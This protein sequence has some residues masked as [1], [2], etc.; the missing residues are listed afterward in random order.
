VVAAFAIATVPAAAR[1]FPERQ[2][3]SPGDVE[4]VLRQAVAEAQA[5]DRL[6]DVAVVDRVGNVLAFYAMDRRGMSLFRV[7]AER[8]VESPAGLADPNFPPVLQTPLAAIAK[9]ITGAYLSS[10]GNAFSTRTAN[11]I[12]Q[13]NFLPG[14]ENL[15]GG[16]LF[17]VQFSSLP[18]SDLNVRFASDARGFIDP[19]AGPKRSPLGLAADPGG[20]PLYKEG[21]LVGGVGVIADGRYGLDRDV[22]DRDEDD[23]ELIAVAAARGFDPAED[24]RADRITVDGRTL[25]FTDV[26]S[27][28]L[29]TDEGDANLVSLAASGAFVAVRGYYGGG[30]LAGQAFG[31]RGSGYERD[32]DGIFANDRAFVLTTGDG[33][34]RFRPRAGAGPGALTAG[35]VTVILEEALGVALMARGQIQR[36]LGENNMEVTISVVDTNGTIL[37]IV[38]TPDGLVFGTDVSLQKARSAMFFSNPNAAGDLARAPGAAG[39]PV[40]AFFDQPADYIDRLGGFLDNN[41]LDGDVAFSERSIGNLAR[42][43]FPDGINDSDNG[44]LSLPFARWSPFNVGLQLDLSAGNIAQHALFVTRAAGATDTPARCTGLPR[45]ANGLQIFPGGFPIYRHDALVGGI[46]VSGDGIDQDD[47]VAFLGL[48]R[49]RSRLNSGV[50]NAPKDRRSD[51]L[52]PQNTNLRYVQ[53]PYA[54]FLNSEDQSVCEGK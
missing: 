35:E 30:V 54:P 13:E 18:C 1:G 26:T 11:T 32:P 43:F 48:D 17:G 6:A 42:P 46:G 34:P 21:V 3:L 45:L 31:F 37:G 40:A 14:S 52:D 44:P 51:R 16:P 25:R 15:E 19:T 33:T 38:R 47:M 50:Q 4:R 53:C 20:F 12:V 24:I 9:A 27:D 5:R 28:D 49:A 22:R 36:P 23:D 2:L 10:N 39:T 8:E 41:S 7:D 29:E